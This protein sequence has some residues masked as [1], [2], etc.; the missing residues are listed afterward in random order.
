MMNDAE[1]YVFTL[2]DMA[3]RGYIRPD[4]WNEP[5]RQSD[6]MLA[7]RCFDSAFDRDR[8]LVVDL[9]FFARYGLRKNDDPKAGRRFIAEAL[10]W[11]TWLMLDY[12]KRAPAERAGRIFFIEDG[13]RVSLEDMTRRFNDMYPGPD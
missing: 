6:R 10:P 2:L 8:G 11:F 7:F 3:A 1:H 9:E 13:R 5:R 4:S 12:V